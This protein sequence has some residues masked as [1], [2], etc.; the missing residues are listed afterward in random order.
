M[1]TPEPCSRSLPEFAFGNFQLLSFTIQARVTEPV[2][3]LVPANG[4]EVDAALALPARITSW[5]AAVV[6]PGRHILPP[7]KSWWGDLILRTFLKH[8]PSWMTAEFGLTS[9]FQDNLSPR[10]L[11]Q[12]HCQLV[13]KCC[14][15]MK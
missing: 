8:C 2:Q 10:L 3:H 11:A 4:T 7:P 13:P 1:W 5:S 15:M 14:H 12:T 9:G 6:A